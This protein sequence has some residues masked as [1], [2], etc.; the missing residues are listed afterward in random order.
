MKERERSDVE[1]KRSSPLLSH[2]RSTVFD[3]SG[4]LLRE[5]PS[6]AHNATTYRRDLTSVQS[7]MKRIQRDRKQETDGKERGLTREDRRRTMRQQRAEI[8]KKNQTGVGPRSVACI[9]AIPKN[10]RKS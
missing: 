2:R 8:E 9:R 1:K 6:N 5:C 7:S 3:N 4:T 10:E